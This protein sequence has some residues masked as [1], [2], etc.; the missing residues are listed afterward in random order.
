MKPE[1]L[2]R[3]DLLF[4][5]VHGLCRVDTVTKQSRP[6]GSVLSYSLVPK[7]V[8]KTK[9]RFVILETDLEVSGFH[10]VISVKEVKKILNYLKA[11][12]SKVEQSGSTWVLARNIFSFSKDNKINARDPKKRQSIEYSIK[13]LVSEV[14]YVLRITLKDAAGKIRKH[15]GP[16]KTMHPLILSAF[17]NAT[18]H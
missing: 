4:H 16:D 6:G 18:E 8:S 14:A 13:G 12:S 3:R 1:K 10:K 2:T 17:T 7:T 5:P 9:V 15:L 11:G